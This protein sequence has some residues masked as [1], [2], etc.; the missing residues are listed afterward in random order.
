MALI[1]MDDYTRAAR[2]YWWTVVAAGAACFAWALAGISEADPTTQVQVAMVATVAALVGL[3]P[4]RIFGTKMSISGGE[5][6]IFLALLVYGPHAAVIAATFEGA[7]AAWRT[8]RRWTSRIGA[9]AMLALAMTVCATG[10]DA[11]RQWLHANG[12]DTVAILP[13]CLL[14]GVIYFAANTG[15][16]STLLALK[17][18]EPLRPLRWWSGM[19]WIGLAYATSALVAALLFATFQQLGPQVLL[20]SVPMIAMFLYALHSHFAR[21]E[22]DE[23]HLRQLRASEARFHSAFS[24]AAIGMLLASLEGHVTQANKAFCAMVGV[25]RAKLL[26]RE[27][28]SLVAEQDAEVV[29]A[30][31][32]GVASGVVPMAEGEVRARREGGA[33]VCMALHISLA[34]DWQS[35]FQ[36]FVIQAQDVTARRRAESE[37]YHNA[38]HDNLTGLPN[39]KRFI[40]QLRDAIARWQ[41]HPE[42]HFAAM[43]LDFDRFKMV[44][45]SLGHRAGDDLLMELARRL[46]STVRPSDMVA[47]LGGDEFAV[48]AEDLHDPRQALE[49]A[50]RLQRAI[51]APLVLGGIDLEVSASIGITFSSNGYISPDDVLRDADLAMYQAKDRGRAQYALFDSSL[52]RLVSRRLILESQLRR[53]LAEDQMALV[54]QPIED[55]ANHRLMGFEALVRWHHPEHGV[56]EPAAF[57]PVAEESGLI[58]PLGQWVLRAACR[59]L[60]E[61]KSHPECRDLRLSVNVSSLELRQPDFVEYVQ[62]ML[63]EHGVSGS[64]LSLE[65]TETVLMDNIASALSKLRRLRE[66][67]ITLGIDDFGTGY[68][69]LSYLATLPIDVLKV[70]RSFIDPLTAG[71]DGSE[72]ATAIFR[73][74][75]ALGKQVFA[76]GIETGAQL[77]RLIKL[78]CRFGQGYLL[79]RPLDAEGALRHATARRPARAA[80]TG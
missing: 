8:S 54:Y 9:P 15:L 42:R 32:R 7:I 57:I 20:V 19:A 74:G 2:V 66:L 4:V 46:A 71:G 28:V 63:D 27:L 53:A 18:S 47:R 1:D 76:E 14:F 72:I 33:E 30:M 13:A 73:L 36:H 51:A 60:A 31:C 5:I 40:E 58:V 56:L 37:L 64:R 17:R 67:G 52:H 38:F 3:F 77:D 39:R 78:G 79:S 34:D 10:F 6:F 69:S 59:K 29:E 12:L 22:S 62:Q 24:D 44:N 25:P 65:V 50:E 80:I 23:T 48:L 16:T 11:T 61:W 41:R 55:L 35:G 75:D 70:D 45:D 21:R 43:Y 68:S 49:M 26:E